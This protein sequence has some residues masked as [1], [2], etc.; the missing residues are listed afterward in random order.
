MSPGEG[1][2]PRAV[3]EEDDEE[4]PLLAAK[5][6]CKIFPLPMAFEERP[7]SSPPE[8]WRGF[9][10]RAP[11]LDQEDDDINDDDDDDDDDDATGRFFFIGSS[12]PVTVAPRK[13]NP[14]RS[15][16]STFFE[17][18]D[19]VLFSLPCP[20]GATAWFRGGA[21]IA[22]AS[23]TAMTGDTNFL[24]FIL[25]N[26]LPLRRLDEEEEDDDDDAAES[27]SKWLLADGKWSLLV[28]PLLLLLLLLLLILI[29]LSWA[30]LPLASSAGTLAVASKVGVSSAGGS[31]TALGIDDEGDHD[32]N[33]KNGGGGGGGGGGRGAST[34][35]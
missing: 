11:A 7:R 32:D 22:L 27:S 25:R 35:L 13:A 34:F 30:S 6:L 29:L 24:R 12:F 18:L 31:T 33:D 2:G 5:E 3:S 19:S 28:A 20:L 10:E 14:S 8:M 4:A 9:T 15:L 1:G 23:V 17:L 26:F 21:A 16:L